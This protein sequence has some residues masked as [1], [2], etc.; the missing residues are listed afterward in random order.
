MLIRQCIAIITLVVAGLALLAYITGIAP[1]FI[2]MR[3]QGKVID[4]FIMPFE[5]MRAVFFYNGFG[6]F[7]LEFPNNSLLTDENVDRL[8]RLNGVPD[9]YD[10][11]LA[12]ETQNVTDASV[13]TL[14]RLVSVDTL[15]VEKSA[16]SADGIAK[17]ESLLP[18]GTVAEYYKPLDNNS[19]DAETVEAQ[20]LD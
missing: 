10:L 2:F 7:I 1:Y 11:T 16:I 8:L 15:F 12:I 13:E 3:E 14:G 6:F 17:L 5:E 9:K 19:M 18:E 20:L 4:E